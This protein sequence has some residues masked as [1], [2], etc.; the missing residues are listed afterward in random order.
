[1]LYPLTE[2]SICGEQR[3]GKWRLKCRCRKR[4]ELKIWESDTIFGKQ[5]QSE[6]RHAFPLREFMALRDMQKI[7]TFGQCSIFVNFCALTVPW[8]SDLCYL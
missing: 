5:L 8:V 4:Q 1:M 6:L 7:A 2:S 3:L